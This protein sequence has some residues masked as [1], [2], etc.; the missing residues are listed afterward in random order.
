MQWCSV[1]YMQWCSVQY[2]P[3]T[4]MMA[5]G[6]HSRVAHPFS[7][8]WGSSVHKR[9]R[10]SMIRKFQDLSKQRSLRVSFISGDVHLAAV[11]LL[12]R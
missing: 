2:I 4:M 3:R 10:K 6:N 7:I 12:Y 1:Q 9:E 5:I 8:Q 11:G